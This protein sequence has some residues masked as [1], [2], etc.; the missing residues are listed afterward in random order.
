MGRKDKK[1][2]NEESELLPLGAR[3]RAARQQKGVTLTMMAS[4]L[5][6]T[7]SHLSAVENGLG[8]PSRELVESY[9]RALGLEPGELTHTQIGEQTM[10]G[11]RHTSMAV[12]IRK[13]VLELKKPRERRTE[14][15]PEEV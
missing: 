1:V 12:P 6:Y 9:E 5:A 14:S 3:M 4:Q 8:R 11:H 15:I 7:K 2:P 10:L 13:E